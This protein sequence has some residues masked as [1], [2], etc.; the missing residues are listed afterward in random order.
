MWLGPNHADQIASKHLKSFGYEQKTIVLRQVFWD[1]A[2]FQGDPFTLN[3]GAKLCTKEARKLRIATHFMVRFQGPWEPDDQE[4]LWEVPLKFCGFL[5]EE[6]E[7][8][9][10]YLN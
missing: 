9:S 3:S 5:G 2:S 1:I 7:R 6:Y 10:L 4:G 8:L